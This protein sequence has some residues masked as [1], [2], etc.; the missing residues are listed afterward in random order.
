M[1][2]ELEFLQEKA[3]K[4]TLRQRSWNK[5]FPS[6][7]MAKEAFKQWQ[8]AGELGQIALQLCDGFCHGLA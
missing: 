3:H 8:Y 2:I 5:R 7:C 4:L 6:P 1:Y